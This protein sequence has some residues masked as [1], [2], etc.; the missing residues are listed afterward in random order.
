M[1]P[2]KVDLIIVGIRFESLYFASLLLEK[3]IDVHLI[4][5]EEPP[6]ESPFLNPVDSFFASDMSALLACKEKED[7]VQTFDGGEFKAF[8]GFG[9][10]YQ[11]FRYEP[12]LHTHYYKWDED[13][14]NQFEKLSEQMQDRLHY[15]TKI[16]AVEC[17]DNQVNA[18]EVNEQKKVRLNALCWSQY[19]SQ[20]EAYLEQERIGRKTLQRLAKADFWTRLDL[21]LLHNEAFEAPLNERFLLKAAKDEAKAF[22]GSFYKNPEGR[23]CSQWTGYIASQLSDSGEELGNLLR[24]KKRQIKRAFKG[25][26]DS[27]EFEKIKMISD[28]YNTFDEGQMDSLQLGSYNNIYTLNHNFHR[29]L[30]KDYDLEYLISAAEKVAS[31]IQDMKETDINGKT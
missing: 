20:W 22:L 14:Q 15:R 23:I 9:D 27:V 7:A 29:L 10:D 3:G 11:D 5:H 25:L 4:D 21:H 28:I 12:Y 16:S 30:H 19:F 8:M 31:K 2:K 13:K 24:E 1:I 17:L 18:I 6:S 26:F